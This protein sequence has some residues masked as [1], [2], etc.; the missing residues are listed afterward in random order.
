MSN[1]FYEYIE[2]L[3][4]G[5]TYPAVTDKDVRSF[6]IPVPPLPEQA[7]IVS[8]LDAISERCNTLQANYTKTITLCDDMKQA[9]LRKAFSGEL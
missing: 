2:P 8:R 9:L 1:E 3:Q 7:D 6:E 5:A 4:A